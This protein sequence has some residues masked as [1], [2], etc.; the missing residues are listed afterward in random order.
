MAGFLTEIAV[1]VHSF[2]RQP[3]VLARFRAQVAH[4][5][6]SNR[7]TVRKAKEA[8]K[9]NKRLRDFTARAPK[10]GWEWM[11][12]R[13][14]RQWERK[15]HCGFWA[16]PTLHD[17]LRSLLCQNRAVAQMGWGDI[18]PPTAKERKTLAYVVLT[19]F[20]DLDKNLDP[21]I[22][23]AGE[24][25]ELIALHGDEVRQLAGGEDG[26]AVLTA[27]A[28]DVDS[29]APANVRRLK[30][31]SDTG[32]ALAPMSLC[33]SIEKLARARTEQEDPNAPYLP[34][35]HFKNVHGIG[36][37]RLRQAALRGRLARKCVTK[38][39]RNTYHYSEPS[40]ARLWPAEVLL[41]TTVTDRDKP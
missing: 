28:R 6:R 31:C 36:R 37:D 21:I 12:T 5:A 18:P 22:E 15:V 34:P 7:E 19:L 16:P 32:A 1:A 4:Y 30:P 17:K 14:P 2:T 9:K 35:A 10:P 26:P 27:C 41:A 25:A 23:D 39:K 8:A 24:R 29:D 40:A 13:T 33:G 3:S 11:D 20:H 38:G